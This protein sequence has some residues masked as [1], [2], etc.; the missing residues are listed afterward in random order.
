[1]T[2]PVRREFNQMSTALNAAIQAAVNKNTVNGVEFVDIQAGTSL[3]GHR[4]C[5]LGIKEPNQNNPNLWFWHHPYHTSDN[6]NTQIDQAYTNAYANI[7]VGVSTKT[8]AMAAKFPMYSDFKD[9]Y[10]MLSIS[11][12]PPQKPR[13][14]PE[15]QELGDLGVVL[16]ATALNFSIPKSPTIPTSETYYCTEWRWTLSRPLLLL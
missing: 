3:E 2:I 6:E 9:I 16:S 13:P 8:D 4:F 1:M 14:Y 12:N 7:T 11:I 5:E 10:T 15:R